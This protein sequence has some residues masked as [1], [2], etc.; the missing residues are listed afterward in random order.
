MTISGTGGVMMISGIT[1]GAGVTSGAGAGMEGSGGLASVVVVSV[2]VVDD[3][4]P[5]SLVSV[6]VS[7]VVTSVVAPGVS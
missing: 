6:M 3:D 1:G 5:V 7:P 4:G 2:V